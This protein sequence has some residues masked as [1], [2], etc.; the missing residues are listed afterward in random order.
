MNGITMNMAKAM[1]ITAETPTYSQM[2]YIADWNPEAPFPIYS[3]MDCIEVN[4]C[5]ARSSIDSRK[6][7]TEVVGFV[8][9]FQQLGPD[10]GRCCFGAVFAAVGRVPS[11]ETGQLTGP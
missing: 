2:D 3:Q 1:Y 11:P 7:C 8:G 9:S 5:L 6:G 10:K 4:N